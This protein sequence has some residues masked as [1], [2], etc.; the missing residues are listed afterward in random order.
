MFPDFGNFD[1]QNYSFEFV[2]WEVLGEVRCAALDVKPSGN[3][4]NRGF[5]GRIWVED[6]NY[7]IVRFRGTFT[8]KGLARRAYHF[9]SWRLNTSGTWWMPAYVYT[10][11]S[12]PHDV[13]SNTLWF[14]AQTRVWGY[15]LRNAGDHRENAK[16]LADNPDRRTPEPGVHRGRNDIPARR[17][18]SGAGASC[19]TYGSRRRC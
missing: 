7:G 14:K 6:R 13:A 17:H 16:P 19:W 9:D 5:V 18:C 1:R 15:D 2:R 8:S 10:E 11:E 3:S 4:Q 12:R